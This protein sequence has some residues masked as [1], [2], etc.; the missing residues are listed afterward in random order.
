MPDPIPPSNSAMAV[1]AS[2]LKAQQSRMRV[3]AETGRFVVA[4]DGPNVVV[5]DRGGRGQQRHHDHV[6]DERV[7]DERRHGRAG[8]LAV[9]DDGDGDHLA[10]TQ[11]AL[12]AHAGLVHRN[13]ADLGARDQGRGD[14]E[15]QAADDPAL[16]RALRAQRGKPGR[17]C[18]TGPS[19][20]RWRGEVESAA[21]L[22]MRAGTRS[23]VSISR[24]R[25]ESLRLR[26]MSVCP[27]S[28]QADA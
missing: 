1:A 21:A 22:R 14:P 17:W 16:C 28:G 12:F 19:S 24:A 7:A 10:R 2:A 15:D 25:W 8:L 27:S 26:R 3:I 4:E 5:I 11:R 23:R 13:H 20:P 9:D 18:G 6:Q